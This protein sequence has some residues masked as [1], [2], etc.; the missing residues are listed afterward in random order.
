MRRVAIL[1]DGPNINCTSWE[2]GWR[3][4]ILKIP[5]LIG[6]TDQD[7]VTYGY[8]FDIERTDDSSNPKR[9][10][11][12][13]KQEGYGVIIEPREK[14]VDTAI[15]VVLYEILLW[16]SE[17]LTDIVLVSGD[18]V[19]TKPLRSANKLGIRT[20]IISAENNLSPLYQTELDDEYNT[21]YLLDD[22]EI[23]D[24]VSSGKL[25]TKEPQESEFTQTQQTMKFGGGVARLTTRGFNNQ[26][27]CFPISISDPTT[28][29]QVDDQEK[30]FVKIPESSQLGFWT[31]RDEDGKP[32]LLVI[33]KQAGTNQD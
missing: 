13:I 28:G 21:I 23:K 5:Q 16:Y 22:E 25:I 11:T 4:D 2:Q 33:L 20:H 3:F 9:F 12:Q 7:Q 30:V 32:Y 15:A 31:K 14:D 17:E 10:Y 29:K 1:V 19:F 26:L 27:D 6:L 8:F 18:G 24:Q